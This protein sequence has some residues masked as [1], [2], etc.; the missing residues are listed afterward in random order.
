MFKVEMKG[1][2]AIVTR[3]LE[4]PY[5]DTLGKHTLKGSFSVDCDLGV[6]AESP[7]AQDVHRLFLPEYQKK[8]SA[9]A[10][11]RAKEYAELWKNAEKEIK[12]LLSDVKA[13]QA[14]MNKLWKS[15]EDRWQQFSTVDAVKIAKPV[16]DAAVKKAAKSHKKEL[17]GAKAK[18]AL[19]HPDNKSERVGI[20]KAV[21]AAIGTASIAGAAA[22][23]TPAI[24]V[25]GAAAFLLVG[26]K[27]LRD[28]QRN[29]WKIAQRQ[30]V[31]VQT[32]I[33]TIL[34]DLQA[35]EKDLKKTDGALAFLPKNRKSLNLQI[36]QIKRGLAD[37]VAQ[38]E[39]AAAKSDVKELAKDASRLKAAAKDLAG[40][41]KNLAEIL[42]LAK[43]TDELE[44]AVKAAQE[45]VAKAVKVAQIEQK[46]W[47]GLMQ[48]LEKTA[49]DTS[50]GLGA[51]SKAANSI[52]KWVDAF[53]KI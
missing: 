31:D 38:A 30:S 11:K 1:S 50:T 20:L 13:S 22:T 5:T 37:G 48:R 14:R 39:E 17:E 19:S 36:A 8:L 42:A 16:L 43:Q 29:A 32:N 12:P 23:A 18:V 53:L 34:A 7:A 28:G 40:R 21:M 15:F 45:A 9:V 10:Q 52:G 4:L 3:F 6:K 47:D 41:E 33:A 27:A 24:A 44:R 2:K 26:L 35:A 25:G 49:D 51:L 46:G